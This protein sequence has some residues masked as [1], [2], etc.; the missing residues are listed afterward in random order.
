MQLDNFL[1]T[2]Y[3]LHWRLQNKL[4]A[5]SKIEVFAF[6]TFVCDLTGIELDYVGN[7]LYTSPEY[8]LI[9]QN[10]LPTPSHYLDLVAIGEDKKVDFMLSSLLTTTDRC[11]VHITADA[12]LC[13]DFPSLTNSGPR[14]LN[15]TWGNNSSMRWGEHS[16]L[17]QLRTMVSDMEALTLIP[18]AADSVAY[19]PAA[20]WRSLPDEVRKSTS[21]KMWSWSH[22]SGDSSPIGYTQISN[23]LPPN[24]NWSR[25]MAALPR[26]WFWQGFLPVK[27]KFC[28]VTVAR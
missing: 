17:F 16:T 26:E 23:W 5:Q 13:S 21:N 22:H 25:Q 2:S 28:L 10:Q 3:K 8:V 20:N 1:K 7:C 18:A 24:P 14:Y 19:H 4:L 9:K 15:S 12:N 11:S 27:R 6:H